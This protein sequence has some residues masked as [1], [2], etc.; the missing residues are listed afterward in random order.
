MGQSFSPWQNELVVDNEAQANDATTKE[1][2]LPRDG[3]IGMIDLMMKVTNGA[4]GN[5]GY[6][7]APTAGVCIMD[8]ITQLSIVANGSKSIL[9]VTSIEDL[10]AEAIRITGKV[11]A[12]TITEAAS[13]VQ[14]V[15]VPIYMG[16]YPDDKLMVLPNGAYN[17]GSFWDSL[18]MRIK[19]S[20]A[21]AA[22]SWAT[23]TVTFTVGVRK[24]VDGSPPQS[25]LI[26]LFKK[27]VDY[28]TVASGDE[29]KTLTYGQNTSLRSIQVF[30]YE[31]GINEAVD[32]THLKLDVSP[33][34]GS[35]I[36]YGKWRWEQL[37]AHNAQTYQVSEMMF[38]GRALCSDTDVISTRVPK[39]KSFRVETALFT[40]AAALAVESKVEALAGDQLTLGTWHIGD[41]AAAYTTDL[42]NF[43]RVHTDVIP[44][45]AYIDFDE[46]RSLVDILDTGK[47][48]DLVLTMTNGGAGGTVRINEE[49]VMQA[50]QFRAA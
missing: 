39:V 25:K 30:C 16:R 44:R 32:L 6:S 38:D 33:R 31:A 40:V 10:I 28:T 14:M 35:K 36:E 22:T 20:A 12:R 50:V 41:T 46:N 7:N 15:Y 5:T 13:G 45:Y 49:H 19:Y 27:K 26:K 3:H 37:Q 9:E 47:L 34:G 1:I 11:P 24:L 8:V 2:K 4:T 23:G 18:V 17:N 42:A 48:S 43:W 29:P 21:I